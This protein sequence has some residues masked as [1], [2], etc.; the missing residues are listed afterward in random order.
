LVA[1]GIEK[2]KESKNNPQ[3]ASPMATNQNSTIAPGNDDE[4]FDDRARN[5]TESTL[6]DEELAEES[7]K[8]VSISSKDE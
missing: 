3:I 8:L 4:N 2:I 7:Q 5:N 1:I 6:Q